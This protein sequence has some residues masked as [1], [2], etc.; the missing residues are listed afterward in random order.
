MVRQLRV[1]KRALISERQKT[2]ELEDANTALKVE[3][4][5]LGNALKEKVATILMYRLAFSER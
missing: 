1:V 5:R 3:T 4:D 2:R